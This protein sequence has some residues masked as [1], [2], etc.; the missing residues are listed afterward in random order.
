MTLN[1]DVNKSKLQQDIQVKTVSEIN[2]AA[3]SNIPLVKQKTTSTEEFSKLGISQEEYV[4]LCNENP[5]FKTLDIDAQLKYIAS[6]STELRLEQVNEPATANISTT[7]VNETPAENTD[8][9]SKSEIISFFGIDK[10]EY[11]KMSLSDK[12]NTYV[13][14]LTKNKF[15]YNEQN[16]QSVEAWENLPEAERNKLISQTKETITNANG[17]E[18][19]L[20]SADAKVINLYLDDAM[21]EL[22][23]A[24][25]NQTSIEE[26]QKMSKDMQI[27]M[28]YDYLRNLE[29]MAPVEQLS[30]SNK[31]FLVEE[32]LL[33][34]SVNFLLKQKDPSHQDIVFCPD[35]TR[36]ILKEQNLTTIEAKLLYLQHKQ[37]TDPASLTEKE[38]IQLKG[39]QHFNTSGGKNLLKKAKTNN[40]ENDLFK[41]QIL[42]SEY[43]KQYNTAKT[44]TAKAFVAY[45][46]IK[47]ISR[48]DKEFKKNLT[49]YYSSTNQENLSERNILTKYL[50]SD[51]PQKHQN[52]LVK[53]KTAQGFVAVNAD[54]MNEETQNT[55]G[56]E[57]NAR[58][59]ENQ[60]NPAETKDIIADYTTA[61]E[62][63]LP[64]NGTEL[65]VKAYQSGNTEVGLKANN[66]TL[67]MQSLKNINRMTDAVI[68]TGNTN[69]QADAA[70][71]LK[72][73]KNDDAKLYGLKGLMGLGKSEV[74]LKAAD[75]PSSFKEPELQKEGAKIVMN[76]SE[77]LDEEDAIKVQTILS[78]DIVECDASVQA[79]IHKMVS[80]SKYEE[81]VQ[82]A[83]ENIYKYDKSAQKEAL[84]FTLETGN[85]KAIENAISNI[86]KCEGLANETSAL[87][88]NAKDYDSQLA[89]DIQTYTAQIEQ[90]YT[91]E[92]AKD[93]ASYMAEQD[94]R[95]GI[96]SVDEEKTEMQK[97]IEKFKNPNVNKFALL[98]QLEPSLR[99]EA[100]KALVKYAPTMINAFIDMGYGP[101]ILKIIGETSDMA[102]NIVNLM[103]F[104][105]QA[106]VKNIVQKYPDNF[107]EL[108]IKYF[109]ED[110]KPSLTQSAYNTSPFGSDNLL[111]RID[112]SGKT[113]FSI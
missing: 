37:D 15:I 25:F 76:G 4:K 9:L 56:T 30:D 21:T 109:A 19:N 39:L 64:E 100:L 68:E 72:Q 78:D 63:V 12:F 110:D 6:R 22:Q 2:S 95:S 49:L 24:N 26:F 20:F 23:A 67:K 38:K 83:A 102:V 50:L 103:D 45:N 80:Q 84:K 86:D 111:K 79:D 96:I 94:L 113:F 55:F 40:P 18:K 29:E 7:S 57:L 27:E 75:T 47:S 97:Y 51:A 106:E 93:Y 8:K 99:K 36:N 87:P 5:T 66:L 1:V 52:E 44:D 88:S 112:K 53:T 16:P 58:L 62:T 33:S 13:T 14:E 31:M 73:L 43:G 17:G 48:N 70:S 11:N 41:K 90:K 89:R 3:V 10:S 81:V 59:E 65:G 104:K 61:L 46:Y 98:G 54:L 74:S 108:Y 82:H 77:L 92:V 60:N 69:I 28:Q 71:K 85:E 105:G 107:E 91:Q 35:Q 34:D 101:D 42:S 32:K